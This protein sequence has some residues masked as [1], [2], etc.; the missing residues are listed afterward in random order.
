MNRESD[1][2]GQYEIRHGFVSG[3]FRYQSCL[4]RFRSMRGSFAGYLEFFPGTKENPTGP[5]FHAKLE[6][7][8]LVVPEFK[9]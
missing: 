1:P 6:P 8:Q 3:A 4:G 7:F 9:Y 5:P 2:H